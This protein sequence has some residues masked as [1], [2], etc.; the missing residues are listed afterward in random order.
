[1]ARPNA[2]EHRDPEKAKELLEALSTPGMSTNR[3]AALVGVPEKTARRF[4]LRNLPVIN[5]SADRK[6][7]ELSPVLR[8]LSFEAANRAKSALPDASARDAAIVM[9]IATEKGLL[10]DGRPSQIS[11]MVHE[12]R[13]NFAGLGAVLRDALESRRPVIDGEVEEALEARHNP[14]TQVIDGEVTGSE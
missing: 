9:G 6:W 7:E 10:I 1:M 4:K 14:P 8:D 5:E 3:A 11:A 13:H 2:L 12:H